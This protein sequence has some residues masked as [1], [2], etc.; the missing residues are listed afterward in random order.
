MNEFVSSAPAEIYITFFFA[1]LALVNPF[2]KIPVFLADTA[3]CTPRVR[4]G[5]AIVLSGAVY[6]I[7]VIAFFAGKFILDIFSISI[8]AFRIAG[9]LIIVIYGL[10]MVAEKTVIPEISESDDD[11][12][13]CDI[14]SAKAKLSDIIVPLGIPFIAGPGTLTTVILYGNMA[15]TIDA[16][17]IMMGLM[18]AAVII[19][20]V[21]FFFSDP[22]RRFLGDSGLE[23]LTRV[24][25]LLLVALGVQFFIVGIGEIIAGWLTAGLPAA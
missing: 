8:P 7:L 15:G 14:E 12:K 16:V 9:G 25:G 21:V 20:G 17:F 13:S 1:L 19:M 2:N 4:R 22:I 23:V 3:G 11:W 6:A 24:M 10:K 18:L 5:V